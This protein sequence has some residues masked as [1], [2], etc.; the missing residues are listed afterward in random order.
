MV[1]VAGGAGGRAV[2][3]AAAQRG[4]GGEVDVVLELDIEEL[5]LALTG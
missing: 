3:A 2:A 4:G 5:P 1:Q